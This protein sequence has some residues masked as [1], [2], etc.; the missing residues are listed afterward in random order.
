M[1]LLR[2]ANS[3]VSTR[4]ATPRRQKRTCGLLTLCSLTAPALAHAKP[5]RAVGVKAWTSGSDTF[6]RARPSAQVP[7]VAKVPR[8]T[9]LY[10]W[11]K[12]NGWYRVE[13]HDHIFGWV[14]N[15]YIE[16][17]KSYKVRAM[18]ATKA[19]L[20]S[21]R[22]A[23]QTMY[24]SPE[25]LKK[26]YAAYGAPGAL[27]GLREHG[28]RL[29]VAPKP[30]PR[31]ASQAK[32]IVAKASVKANRPFGEKIGAR[33]A[34]KAAPRL[35][36][37][38]RLT[39]KTVGAATPRVAPVAA[40][41]P[42]ATLQVAS[43]PRPVSP[44][45]SAERIERRRVVAVATTPEI[46]TATSKTPASKAP[47][48][49]ASAP[50]EKRAI[51]P[52]LNRKSGSQAPSAKIYSPRESATS[53]PVM[54]EAVPV[55]ARE[56]E[57]DKIASS[58]RGLTP[59]AKDFAR[60][61]AAATQ[62]DAE[63]SATTEAALSPS[64]ART[65][66]LQAPVALAPTTP[67]VK[68]S[69]PAPRKVAKKPAKKAV[70][71]G[72]AKSRYA[73][74]KE[75][76][77]QQ[78]RAK[79]GMSNTAP[80]SV[81][82]PVSP[83]ELMRARQEYLAERKIRL[84]LPA[85]PNPEVPSIGLAPLPLPGGPLGGPSDSPAGA[86]NGSTNPLPPT[87]PAGF[88]PTAFE[89]M[90]YESSHP[91]AP[92][93]GNAYVLSLAQLKPRIVPPTGNESAPTAPM[94]VAV[95]GRGGSPRDRMAPNRGG[96]PRDRFGAGMANQ[97]LSYRGMPYIRGAA[98]PNRGFDC[99]GLVFYLLS[100]RGY[101]PPRTAAGYA[102][103]GV[104]VPKDQLKSGD[105]LLFANT[106][107]RGISHIGVYLGEGKFVHAAT[108]STGVRVSSLKEAYYAGKYYGARRPK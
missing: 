62:R 78:L 93:L 68:V 42:V 72:A 104:G 81:I 9:P 40:L 38:P 71:R 91:L 76:Q 96:S 28:I 12:Y 82:A 13:T 1:P 41:K 35:A 26:H 15:Q 95:P 87:P 3:V 100:Q 64:S 60:L 90:E 66:P 73:A 61:A 10:V 23:N 44:V 48:R 17:P 22:T 51:A 74:R 105:L 14:F 31:A 107:K 79:M 67:R 53:A 99:S 45:P 58:A 2:P 46:K 8:H 52:V 94:P 103:W 16:A 55:T 33:P 80:R 34:T 7:P 65:V 47:V 59:S 49:V 20:A 102:K 6:I 36:S 106:Y 21:N 85:T 63:N 37:V 98:S 29:A 92:L 84:G 70:A 39:A 56:V 101:H 54:R 4:K 11:G 25:L 69:S 5:F 57:S 83:A 77:R 97:A 86:S 89:P 88:S 75:R 18:P 30:Q 43:A 24:G 32:I 27:K 19:Q 108:S 50:V